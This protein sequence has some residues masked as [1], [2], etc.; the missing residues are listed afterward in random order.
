M[1]GETQVAEWQVAHSRTALSFAHRVI[2][3]EATSIELPVARPPWTLWRLT[4]DGIFAK[5]L[6]TIKS[7]EWALTRKPPA[8]PP[9]PSLWSRFRFTE[10]TAGICLVMR[11]PGLTPG[12]WGEV[13]SKVRKSKKGLDFVCRSDMEAWRILVHQR[14]ISAHLSRERAHWP[15]LAVDSGDKVS[16]RLGS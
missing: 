16:P 8:P 1:V 14:Q 3:T 10:V 2:T 4:G 5:I 6:M 9:L 13:R 7:S 11:F 15:S 12:N